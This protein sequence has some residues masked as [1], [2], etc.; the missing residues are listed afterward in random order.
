MKLYNSANCELDATSVNSLL[1]ALVNGNDPLDSIRLYLSIVGLFPSEDSDFDDEQAAAKRTVQSETSAWPQ[2]PLI[3]SLK[4]QDRIIRFMPSQVTFTVLF[5]AIARNLRPAKKVPQ[6]AN[7]DGQAAS[8]VTMGSSESVDAES[9]SSTTASVFLKGARD[10][11][12]TMHDRNDENE[13][14][15]LPLLGKINSSPKVT[16]T[17]PSS[18]MLRASVE[19]DIAGMA[20][21]DSSLRSGQPVP[22]AVGTTPAGSSS[23]SPPTKPIEPH[24]SHPDSVLEE[25][26]RQL[27]FDFN[28]IPDDVMVSVL[29][30]LFQNQRNS[31][32]GAPFHWRSFKGDRRRDLTISRNF[33][34]VTHRSI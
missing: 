16:A 1:R 7:R 18:A 8:V 22:P 5:L 30:V 31:R 2:S 4:L 32:S 14:L 29:N 27:R 25:L 26:Y 17:A 9:T 23:P 10:I 11:E 34:C 6:E 15:P 3:N 13:A 28:I 19:D 12:F 21:A 20:I 33:F 24:L